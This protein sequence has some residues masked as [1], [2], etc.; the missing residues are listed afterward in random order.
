M[1]TIRATRTYAALVVAATVL[2]LSAA[3][4]TTTGGTAQPV[5]SLVNS[6]ASTAPA[7]PTTISSVPSS[8]PVRPH[9]PVPPSEA[10]TPRQ[11]GPAS[12][13]SELSEPATSVQWTFIVVRH[14]ERAD[15][16]TDDPPLTGAGSDRASRLADLL[17]PL[18]GVG[19]YAT[20]YQRTQATAQPTSVVWNVPVTTYDAMEGTDE[21][22][23]Q[24]M[25]EHP[26]GTVLI[27]GHSDTVPG[28]VGLLCDCSVDPI[29]EDEF[30]TLYQVT[31]DADGKAV[32]FQERDD[33]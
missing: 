13:S 32:N 16:G 31:V 2:G 12:G 4:T 5:H 27:V 9:A 22:L 17:E 20:T 19:V 29:P 21:L 33:Y 1:P 24:V 7:G 28:I 18:H 30:G 6:T 10:T 15:D 26:S 25:R 23:A 3:C 8:G 11:S 14:A